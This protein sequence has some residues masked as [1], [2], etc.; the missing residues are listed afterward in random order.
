VRGI[1]DEQ[2]LVTTSAED[3]VLQQQLA[4][5]VLF[6]SKQPTILGVV[7]RG[8]ITT[9]RLFLGL[10]DRSG[11]DDLSVVPPLAFLSSQIIEHFRVAGM[12]PRWAWPCSA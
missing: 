10:A 8:P 6:F 5:G 4:K 2:I 11:R 12:S 9:I 7:N 3:D 1:A